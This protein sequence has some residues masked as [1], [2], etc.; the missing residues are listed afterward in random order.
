MLLDRKANRDFSTRFANLFGISFTG[1]I[2]NSGGFLN[3]STMAIEQLGYSVFFIALTS[4]IAAV[5]RRVNDKLSK[6]GL[7]KELI[8]EA[9]AA[10]ELCGCCFELIIGRIAVNYIG[11]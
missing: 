9:I 7:V 2:E 4:A 5:A 11:G 10:A 6:E 8:F 3:C 1:F